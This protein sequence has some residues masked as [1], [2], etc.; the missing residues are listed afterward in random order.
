M[1]GMKPFDVEF[2][3]YPDDDDGPGRFECSWTYGGKMHRATC[4]NMQAMQDLVFDFCDHHDIKSD[5][6]RF[7]P[8][9]DSHNDLRV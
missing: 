8:T 5:G 2:R 9:E 1:R 4:I 7:F 6:V 3:R